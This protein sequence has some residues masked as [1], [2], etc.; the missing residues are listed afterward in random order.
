MKLYRTT[1]GV[2][3][4]NDASYYLLPDA[5]WDSFVNDDQLYEKMKKVITHTT[6]EQSGHGIIANELLAPIQNQEIWASG[7]TYYRSRVGRQE[8]SKESGGGDFY[9]RVY[10]AERPELF[11][12]APAHRTVGPGGKVRIRRDS[13]WDV[14]E[15]ELTLMITKSGKI[16]GYTIGNDM[17]SRSIEGENPLYLPQAKSYDGCASIGPCIYVTQEPLSLDTL[18]QLDIIRDGEKIFEGSTEINQIKRKLPDLVS[19]LYRECT[20]PYGSLLMTGTGIVPGT[21]FTLQKNDEIRITI[22][23]IGTLVNFVE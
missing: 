12:K 16:V 9:A 20:F 5:P 1:R 8:E 6:P 2:L 17:S 7:V 4:E 14:P 21:D 23:P 15:P 13:V 18:I 22:E 19:Y 11:F 3:I 10:E